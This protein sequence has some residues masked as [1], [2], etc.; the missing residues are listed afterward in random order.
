MDKTVLNIQKALKNAKTVAVVGCSAD[1]Y[2]TSNYAA[3]YLIRKGYE[4]IPINPNE[5][6]IL[7]LTCYPDL[8]SIPKDV[9]I[10]IVNIF[11][12]SIHTKGVVD[13]IVRWKMERNQQ[14]VIWTQLDVSTQQ[15]E[16]KAKENEL[17]YIRNKCI[18]VE[19]DHI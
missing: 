1:P 12:K 6:E 16:L 10:D 5:Q 8:N 2:R 7:G 15:A 19:L 11:R 13:E 18:M 4:V 17:P 3:K 9:R 14:P